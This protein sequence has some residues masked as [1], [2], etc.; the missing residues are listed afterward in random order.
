MTAAGFH[1]YLKWLEHVLAR[2]AAM[3]QSVIL[4]A[5]RLME[6]KTIIRS[7]LQRPMPTGNGAEFARWYWFYFTKGS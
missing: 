1:L 4:K 7:S 6:S 3:H 5:L 2:T